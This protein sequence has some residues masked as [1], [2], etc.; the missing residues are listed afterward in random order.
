M[1]LQRLAALTKEEQ[2]LQETL[3]ETEK[4]LIATQEAAA[5]SSAECDD[6]RAQLTQAEQRGENLAQELQALHAHTEHN[7]VRFECSVHADPFDRP[8]CA[9]R[10]LFGV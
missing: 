2:T 3:S 9:H 8:L 5:S 6:L 7:I 1:E 4:K 10:T